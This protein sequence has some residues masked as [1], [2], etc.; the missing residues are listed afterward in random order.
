LIAPYLGRPLG[1]VV[2]TRP[3]VEIVDHVVPG[4]VVLVVVGFG[5]SA[6]RFPLAS[7]L[8]AVL[9]GLWMT[10]THVPLIVQSLGGRVTLS[11]ALWHTIPGVMVFAFAVVAAGL[12][13]RAN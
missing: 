2:D 7:A 5:F 8:V 12:A 4:I 6:P 1:F 11:A 13:W 9:A 3:I 10:A